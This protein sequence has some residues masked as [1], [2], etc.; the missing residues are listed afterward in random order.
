MSIRLPKSSPP[1]RVGR[2]SGTL[3]WQSPGAHAPRP[4]SCG[5][6]VL[7]EVAECAHY[8]LKFAGPLLV[9]VQ[10]HK[11]THTQRAHL[12]ELFR[13]FNTEVAAVVVDSIVGGG[14][15][16]TLGKERERTAWT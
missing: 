2:R 10:E 6:K 5:P 9:K 12:F 3:H 1:V 14:A 16:V 13:L 15:V 4:T 7:L 11:H 8:F